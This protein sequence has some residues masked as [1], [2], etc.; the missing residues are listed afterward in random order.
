MLHLYPRA[1]LRVLLAV[2]LGPGIV[3]WLF[4]KGGVHIGASGMAY[5]LVSYILVAGLIRRDRRAHRRLAAGLL[6]V[7][8]ARVGCPADRAWRVV[9]NA[10]GRRLIGIVLAHRLSA[11][12]R[13]ATQTLLLGKEGD[14]ED[15]SQSSRRRRATRERRGPA[16]ESN[17]MNQPL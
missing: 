2:Y 15:G 3:V 5:G 9:G 13:S 14:A 6:H 11:S 12:R 17:S 7:R 8:R 16:D 1:A 4:A 10:S